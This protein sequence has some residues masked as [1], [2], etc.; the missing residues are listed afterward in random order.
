MDDYEAA[1]IEPRLKTTLAFLTKLTLE[2]FQLTSSDLT[3]MRDAGVNDAAIE[4]AALVCVC[5][6]IMDRLSDAFDF[7]V[8]DRRQRGLLSLLLRRTGYLTASVPG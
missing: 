5:F 4:Q 8:A 6:N 7:T 2:P 3:P 1:D